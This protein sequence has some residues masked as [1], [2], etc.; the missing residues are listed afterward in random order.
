MSFVFPRALA[1]AAALLFLACAQAAPAQSADELIKKGDVH[2]HKLQPAEALKYYLPAEKV[3]PENVL[4]L[5][6]I[7][8]QYRHLMSDAEGRQE[9]IRLGGIAVTYANRAVAL[10]PNEPEAHLAVAVSLGKL[11][12]FQGNRE[13]VEGSRKIKAAA[14][15]VTKLDPRNDL[16]WH[17]LGRWHLVLS[18]TSG[19]QR[20]L[21]SLVYGKLPPPSYQE[22]ERYFEKAIALNP[23]RLMHYIELGRTY[24]GMGRN[25]EA[26][27]LITKGL[28]M[29]ETEKDD[30]DTKQKGRELLA[31]LK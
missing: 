2:Y 24:A 3:E 26:K 19:L 1:P 13:R 29:R 30:P 22:A 15:R 6:K 16:G 31:K 28:A 4:L 8:R 27:R 23:Q 7:A 18:E 17:V 5:V 12:P 14:E 25:E 10:D 20:T 11:L 9:K 21:A